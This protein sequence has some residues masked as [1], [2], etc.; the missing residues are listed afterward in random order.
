MEQ[1]TKRTWAEISLDNIVHNMNTMRARL[2][3]GTKFLGVVKAD[4][5]GHGAV[6]VSRALEA[7][8]ADY[9]AVA[10]LDEAVELREA[11]ISMPILILGYTPP[12]CVPELIANNV[13]QAVANLA[14][15]REYEAAAAA[16]GGTLRIHIKLDT[17]MSRLGF[18]CAGEHFEKAVEDVAAACRCTHLEP[19][20]I[21]T[22]FA[23]SDE[24]G[25]DAEA[26]TRTQFRLFTDVIKELGVKGISFALRHCS[27]SGAV[28]DY[29]ETALDMV[30]P[31]ILLYG[32]GDGGRLG[33]K[34]G[35]RLLS[36]V[37]AVKDY[38]PGTAVS[39]G[40]TFRTER[41][42]RMGVIGIGYADGLHR[43]LSNKCAF[44]VGGGM[45]P[46]RGR[47]CMDMCMIDLTELPEADVGSTVEIFGEHASLDTLATIAGTITYELLCSVS[48][49]VPRIY[50]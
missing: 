19:E 4:A 5:Y 16:C 6:P 38:D 18:L 50:R 47:I 34:P 29:P 15:A 33:L 1:L 28:L 27:N 8:G 17:G 10:C 26:Y 9:L 20:G 14:V 25:A 12:E 45:A 22:H 31:G 32:Y 11:G 44:S 39:Y 21:F 35:M 23:V 13:T 48:K 24:P 2:P 3:A 43:A 36:R 37:C 46:Q 42:T 49:R 30:R 40:G 41:S 7:A